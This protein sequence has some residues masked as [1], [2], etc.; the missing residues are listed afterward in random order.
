[1]INYIIN[2]DKNLT[3]RKARDDDWTI[4]EPSCVDIGSYSDLTKE[5]ANYV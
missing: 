5:I 4:T 2:V 3:E 1:M